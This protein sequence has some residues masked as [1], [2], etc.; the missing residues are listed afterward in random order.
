MHC[1]D[2]KHICLV[3][4]GK[5]SATAE[6]QHVRASKLPDAALAAQRGAVE[7]AEPGEFAIVLSVVQP[8]ADDEQVVYREAGVVGLDFDNATRW[9]IEEACDL[10]GLRL[11]LTF[12]IIEEKLRRSA[13]VDDVFDN[14]NVAVRNVR[15]FEIRCLHRAGALGRATVTR[16]A[17]E[18]H[19]QW[20][21]G[22]DV[23]NKIGQQAK[24]AFH[25]ADDNW[26]FE[27]FVVFADL[28]TKFFD[29]RLNLFG[30]VNL[31]NPMSQRCRNCLFA[32]FCFLA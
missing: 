6:Y 11:E 31:F 32:H 7:F 14:E 25:D 28:C 12:E 29:A 17:H 4:I 3:S 22:F 10:Q 9:F 18:F 13:G 23:A 21:R 15:Q 24:S 26:L 16:Q 20:I 1:Q 2:Y 19:L 8:V 5:T 27:I 30:G